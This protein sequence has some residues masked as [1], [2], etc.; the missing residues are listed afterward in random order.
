MADEKQLR[1]SE[2]KE[3]FSEGRS[4]LQLF[5]NKASSVPAVPIQACHYH[6]P[7]AYVARAR[8]NCMARGIPVHAGHL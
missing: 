7:V 3:I 6:E 4:G 2:G 5:K 1:G 8:W